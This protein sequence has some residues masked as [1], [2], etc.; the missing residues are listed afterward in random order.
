M[1]DL[2]AYSVYDARIE[3]LFFNASRTIENTE[4]LRVHRV[5]FYMLVC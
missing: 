4:L 3:L 5:Y 1:P 2:A